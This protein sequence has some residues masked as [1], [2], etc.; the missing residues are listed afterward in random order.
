MAE[1]DAPPKLPPSTTGNADG[2]APISWTAVASLAVAAGFVVFTALLAAVSFAKQQSLIEPRLLVLPAVAVVLAFV[3]RRQ[4]LASEGTR[5]GLRYANA[6]WYVAV[7]GGLT[8]GTYLLA[9]EFA[10]RNDAESQFLKFASNL[11]Q[12]NPADP[13]DPGIY[14]A[15]YEQIQ[16]GARATVKGPADAAGIDSGYRDLVLGFRSTDL[17]RVC[18]RNPGQVSFKTTGLVDWDQKPRQINCVIKAQMSTP[19]GDFDL[20]VPMRADIEDNRQRRWMVTPTKEGYV[21]G[22]RLTP[23]GWLVEF[24]ELSGRQFAS[25]MMF[26]LSKP[27]YSNLAL[28]AFVLPG[29]DVAAATRFVEAS[30][31]SVPA[32]TAAAGSLGLFPALPPGTEQAF[33]DLFARPDGKPLTDGDRRIFRDAWGNPQ[34]LLPPGAGLKTNAD[35][36]TQLTVTAGQVSLVQSA[37]IVLT[38]DAQP[39]PTARAKILLQLPAQAGA[40]LAAELDRLRNE[41]AGAAKTDVPPVE[42]QEKPRVVPWRV[43]RVVS[44]LKPVPAG[45]SNAMTGGGGGMMGQ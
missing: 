13:L 18:A 8:Y 31:A 29:T 42:F 23:Y 16:P 14:A 38:Q 17:A 35:T 6:G 22:R 30:N 2:Y 27:G 41:A 36:A 26:T 21:K 3:A 37:E 12:L 7:I 45:P 1:P 10:V 28:M 11:K 44:D 4:V 32:R 40:D 9:I 19:E 43:T 24:L 25:E 33:T 5:E 39:P 20:V 34:R 15:V